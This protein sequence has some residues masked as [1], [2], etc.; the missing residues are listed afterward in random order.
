MNLALISLLG[1]VLA[2]DGTSLGQFMVSRPL[3][4]GVLAGTLLGD[5]HSGLWVG[6][7][8]ELLLLAD[9]PVGGAR[10][11]ESGPATVVAVS[12]SLA[13]PWPGGLALGVLCGLLVGQAGGWTIDLLR[14][15]NA[16]V[17]PD[18]TKTLI[19]QG[20]VVVSHLAGIGMDFLR[21]ALL[22]AGGAL[23]GGA[24]VGWAGGMWPLG[25]PSSVALLLLAASVP[26]GTLAAG[27]GGLR[28]TRR[29]LVVGVL[30]GLLGGIFL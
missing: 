16:R 2:V 26:M 30:V 6:G 10:F 23:A 28:R 19:R 14:H 11:P 5:P 29:L 18:G 13:A 8:L 1:G 15:L 22:T 25:L 20:R 7:I 3:V 24:F 27:F 12:A 17:S 4:A 21:G 9:L